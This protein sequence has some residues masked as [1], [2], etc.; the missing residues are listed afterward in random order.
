MKQRIASVTGLILAAGPSSRMGRD[1]LSL[2]F[3]GAPL[4][5]RVVNAAREADLA[6][7]VLV[8][9]RDGALKDAVD[10]SGCDV[11][12]IRD[13]PD[14]ASSFRAGLS[15]AMDNAEGCMVLYG[16]QPLLDAKTLN[17][18]IWAFSQQP[19]YMIAPVQEGLCGGPVITPAGWFQTAME[20]TGDAVLRKLAAMR[21]LTLRLVKIDDPGPFVGV[22]T[23]E[24]Y[25][26]LLALYD[27]PRPAGSAMKPAH[28]SR[29]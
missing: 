24:E 6:R 15:R 8:L 4:L 22:D 16:D 19:E 26:R 29:A 21:G 20:I 25:Q 14:Q 12:L 27:I 1:K 11:V 23:H 7:V 9:P 10:A 28:A 18:L 3:R 13:P 17:H 2:P 5:Q